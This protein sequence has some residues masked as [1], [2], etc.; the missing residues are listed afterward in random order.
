MYFTLVRKLFQKIK[1][2]TCSHGSKPKIFIEKLK[3]R[4]YLFPRYYLT[5][6]NLFR[7]C[8]NLRNWY[9]DKIEN[10]YKQRKSTD[11]KLLFTQVNIFESIFIHFHSFCL[12][13]IIAIFFSINKIERAKGK[14]IEVVLGSCFFSSPFI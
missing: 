12:S 1:Q 11:F 9:I 7:H 4:N 14:Q 13:I 8:I 3:N 6:F 10:Y 5:Y 2:E